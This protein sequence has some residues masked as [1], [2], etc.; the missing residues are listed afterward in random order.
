MT[1]GSNCT[2]LVWGEVSLQVL[3]KVVFEGHSGQKVN[4]PGG[5]NSMYQGPWV[6]L[7]LGNLVISG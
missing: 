2:S 7:N 6:K 3:E 1:S 4:F 5:T